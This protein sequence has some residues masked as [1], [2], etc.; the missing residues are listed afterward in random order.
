MWM[1]K[2]SADGALWGQLCSSAAAQHL[3]FAAEPSCFYVNKWVC[4]TLLSLFEE[5]HLQNRNII[6][7]R[8]KALIQF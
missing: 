2:V 3:R 5:Y 7:H 1:E 6:W 4:Y 8:V